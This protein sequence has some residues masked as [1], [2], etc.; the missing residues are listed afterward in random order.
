LCHNLAKLLI[1]QTQSVRTKQ[2]EKVNVKGY[3]VLNRF[4]PWIDITEDDL[5]YGHRF[6]LSFVRKMLHYSGR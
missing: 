4:I 1:N 6:D 5:H 2:G 3:I